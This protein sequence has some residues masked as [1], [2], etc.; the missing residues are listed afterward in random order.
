MKKLKYFF[1]STL[2][3]GVLLIP[4]MALAQQLPE[5]VKN[6]EVVAR[7]GLEKEIAKLKEIYRGQLAEYRDADKQF[8]IAKDQ[9]NELETLASIN[10]VVKAA[11]DVLMLRD[12]VMITH[13]ELLRNNIVAADGI[14]LSLK[15][16]VIERMQDRVKW[17]EEHRGKLEKAQ[18]RPQFNVLSDE[19]TD[20]EDDFM[21]I[22]NQATTILAVGSMQDVYDRLVLVRKD[23]L[24]LEAKSSTADRS[25]A[26][27][28]T[29]RMISAVKGTLDSNWVELG[30][31]VLDG[32]VTSYSSN[33]VKTLS[34]IYTGL[35]KTVSFLRELLREIK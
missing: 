22:S 23:I 27:I 21:E 24:A 20:K 19:F 33:L 4:S 26:S 3:T 18:D 14:E 35:N 29:D 17:L 10:D 13:F 1:L 2:I 25:R 15:Q 11:R 34:P 7:Q 12:L 31:E 6:E 16:K 32:N 9:Y 28:E 30:E 5:P 8:N